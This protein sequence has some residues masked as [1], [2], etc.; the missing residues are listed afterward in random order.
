MIMAWVAPMASNCGHVVCWQTLAALQKARSNTDEVPRFN[1]QQRSQ[2][3]NGRARRRIRSWAHSVEGVLGDIVDD[4]HPDNNIA[5][6]R[7]AVIYRTAF[8]RSKFLSHAAAAISAGAAMAAVSCHPQAASAADPQR[9]RNT[10]LPPPP[11]LLLPVQRLRVSTGCYD[12]VSTDD[13]RAE[14]MGK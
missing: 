4:G 3:P 13:C 6:D 10:A 9:D 1:R 8:P 14:T 12:C 5:H 11:A 7:D 2:L